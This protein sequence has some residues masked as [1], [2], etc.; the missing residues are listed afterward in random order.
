MITKEEFINVIK[1]YKS[2][3]KFME[4]ADAIGID[5]YNSIICDSSDTVFGS[6][7]TLITNDDGVDLI[8]WWIF[9]DVEKK[10][11]DNDDEVIADLVD[12]E[13]LY[14]YM[15]ENGYF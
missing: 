5:L 4:D 7:L 3:I 11:Y 6:W 10:I 9:E 12:E 13:T 14:N 8:Y 1:A 15:K 2:G